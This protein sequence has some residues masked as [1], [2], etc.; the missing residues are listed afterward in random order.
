MQVTIKAPV[1]CCNTG[2]Q[3]FVRVRYTV[4]TCLLH[5]SDGFGF[6]ICG[7]CSTVSASWEVRICLDLSTSKIPSVELPCTI[8]LWVPLVLIV[9]LELLPVL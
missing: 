2:V 6:R 8:L 7:S 3:G 1:C 5:V 9:R 4:L